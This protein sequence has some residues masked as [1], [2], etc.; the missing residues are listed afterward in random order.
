MSEG[1]L[2]YALK[3]L[4]MGLSVIP[5]LPGTKRPAVE[6][7]EF[8]RRPPTVKKVE[9]W[10]SRSMNVATVCGRVSGGLTVLDFDK[11]ESFEKFFPRWKELLKATPIVQTARG[12]HVWLRSERPCRSF[13]IPELQLDVKGE[14]GYVLA[15]PSVHPSGHIYRFLNP[16]VFEEGH[17]LLVEDVKEDVWRRAEQLGV[18]RV[19]DLSDLELRLEPPKIEGL[20]PCMVRIASGVEEGFRNEAGFAYAAFLYSW[21]KLSP[22][23][24]Y[25]ALCEYADRCRPPLPKT[26]V[27]NILKSVKTKRYIISCRNYRLRRFC[28]PLAQLSCPLKGRLIIVGGDW[29]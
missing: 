11:P 10:F 14:G 15:P 9:E 6:W 4:D 3:Y 22:D 20:P 28:D 7:G 5:I 19:Y 1:C 2:D 18:R 21:L 24:V 27:R 25:K 16:D 23:E 13:K 17:I 12:I 8:Q 29:R 26:E